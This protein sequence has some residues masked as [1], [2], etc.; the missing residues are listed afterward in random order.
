MQI[1]DWINENQPIVA[2]VVIVVLILAF[3][4]I[5]CELMGGPGYSPITQ[6]FYY[7]DLNTGELFPVSYKEVPPI[8]APSDIENDTGENNGVR[9][10]VFSCTDCSDPSTF[11]I[12]YLQRLS[13]EAKEM[14][15]RMKSGEIPPEEMMMVPEEEYYVARPGDSRWVSGMS[16]QGMRLVESAYTEECPDGEMPEECF[17]D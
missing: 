9:A 12:A 15:E 11:K 6:E 16:E 4:R 8:P 3:A 14:H 10:F 5:T 7:Y 2:G 17:P 1:R 13:D